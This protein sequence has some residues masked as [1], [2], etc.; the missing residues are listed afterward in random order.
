MYYENEILRD[1]EESS[2]LQTSRDL[3][4]LMNNLF[5]LLF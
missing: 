5:P 3:S 4:L 1:P 2:S